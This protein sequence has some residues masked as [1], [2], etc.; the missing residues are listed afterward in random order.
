MKREWQ[1]VKPDG[2]RPQW[3]GFYVTMNRKGEIVMNR[4]TYERLGEPTGISLL[5][6]KVNNCV[7]LAPT[8][9]ELRNTFPVC[10]YGKH[11]GRRVRAFKLLQEHRIRI[12]DT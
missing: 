2:R 8:S 7:G 6:D 11:G 5:F 4:V 10:P 12:A 9:K 3:A 1:E